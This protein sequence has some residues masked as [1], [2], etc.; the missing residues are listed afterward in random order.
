VGRV[1]RHTHQGGRLADPALD[2]CTE[3]LDEAFG[4]HL[5]D[6]VGDRDPGEPGGASEVGTARRPVAEERLEEQRTVVPARVLLQ[7]LAAGAELLAHRG[8][9]AHVC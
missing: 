3:L 8:D 5:A 6:Q 2:R 9:L 1:R 4:D 7:Q